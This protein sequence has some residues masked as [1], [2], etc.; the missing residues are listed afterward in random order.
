MRINSTIELFESHSFVY[1]PDRK[2]RFV[3]PTRF[4]CGH[5]FLKQTSFLLI[6]P[7]AALPKCFF[8]SLFPIFVMTAHL[9]HGFPIPFSLI[10]QFTVLA[11]RTQTSCSG[12]GAGWNRTL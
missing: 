2:H 11:K 3:L 10:R 6:R 1:N 12:F 7:I 8:A 9:P 5:F 4:H